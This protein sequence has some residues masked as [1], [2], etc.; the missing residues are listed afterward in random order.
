MR[1]VPSDR[2]RLRV[3]LIVGD[4]AYARAVESGLDGQ[5]GSPWEVD[6]VPDLARGRERLARGDVDVVL[7]D[8]DLTGEAGLPGPP[9]PCAPPPGPAVVTPARARRRHRRLSAPEGGG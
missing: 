1:A 5:S 6:T 2:A 8:F 4:V 3:L 7:A 9:P